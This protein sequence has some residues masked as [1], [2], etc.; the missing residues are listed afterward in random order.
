MNIFNFR[1][2]LIDD[3]AE[4]IAS[5][6]NVRDKRIRDYIDE[7]LKAGVLWPQPLI[8]LNPSFEPGAFVKDLVREG[9]LHQGCAEIFRRG[10]KETGGA[11]LDL[12]LHTHQEEAIRVA[13]QGRNYVLTTGTGSGK[14]LAYMIPIVD[15]VLR[16]GSGKGIKAIVVYPMNALA[17]SHF[18]ELEKFL[19]EGY[20][21]GK[22]PVTFARYTG[23]ERDE[24]RERIVQEPPDILLTNY[25]MLELVLTRPYERP[26]IHAARELEFLVL[27]ELHTY[28][29]RQGA[30]V[31]LLVRR[32]RN[33]LGTPTLQCVGTS[34]TLAGPGTFDEQRKEVSR[35]ASSLFGAPV[36]AADVICETL[37]RITSEADITAP[38][39]VAE[40]KRATLDGP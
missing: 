37:R 28:R 8:Q 21:D 34:A 22:G 33:L 14:S 10:K 9:V 1:D 12:R 38:D 24:V 25:V 29:G 32:V 30:D 27:D 26:L 36:D 3:Y 23:Q 18:G 6:I 35:L 31:S 5:F 19:C 20:P 11:G 40:L 7:K 16:E 17:N 2:E 15:R 4:Y 39:F 13:R